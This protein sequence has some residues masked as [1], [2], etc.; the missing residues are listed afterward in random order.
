MIFKGLDLTSCGCT[1]I[2]FHP[3]LPFFHPDSQCGQILCDGPDPVAFL[4]TDM[5]DAGDGHRAVRKRS[6]GRQCQRLVG[7]S[8]H[9]HC[10]TA[11]QRSFAA[12]H[13]HIL[14]LCFL[15]TAAHFFQHIQ[16]SHIS[17]EHILF[18]SGNTDAH[19]QHCC[20]GIKICRRRHIRFHRIIQGTQL[21]AAHPVTKLCRLGI[22]CAFFH[23]SAKILHHFHSQIHIA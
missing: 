3:V 7:K 16:K 15:Q 22:Y 21:T 4:E 13:F 17:L 2:Y 1:G 8:R 11:L 10:H 12:P 6:N 9:I 20:Q 14:L 23:K 18:D 5:A 19:P